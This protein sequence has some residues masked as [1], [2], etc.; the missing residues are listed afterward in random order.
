MDLSRT[1]APRP[2]GP[3]INAGQDGQRRPR[4]PCYNCGKEGHFA[5]DCRQPKQMKV[6]YGWTQDTQ[7]YQA[8]P[9]WTYTAPQTK[10]DN[11]PVDELQ[12]RVLALSPEDKGRLLQSYGAPTK[13][14][15]EL[16]F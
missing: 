14:T 8:P 7:M 9:G 6:N 16:D 4:G 15:R 3:R 11:D 2:Q 5:R 12:A 10:P 1:R 13:E